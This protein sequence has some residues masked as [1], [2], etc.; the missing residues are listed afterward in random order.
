MHILLSWNSY[1]LTVGYLW[2]QH[3]HS[4]PGCCLSPQVSYKYLFQKAP[5]VVPIHS[6][7]VSPV[8]GFK[9]VLVEVPWQAA[10]DRVAFLVDPPEA[11]MVAWVTVS[12]SQLGNCGTG[13]N[14]CPIHLLCDKELFTSL[15]LSLV[16]AKYS[17]IRVTGQRHYSSDTTSQCYCRSINMTGLGILCQKHWSEGNKVCCYLIALGCS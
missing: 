17:F 8:N 6:G 10:Q 15:P 3:P 2:P 5:D 9:T 13:D 11:L 12:F 4:P 1:R 14:S 7:S 16:L